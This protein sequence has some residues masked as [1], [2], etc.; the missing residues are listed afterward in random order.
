MSIDQER[1]KD[2]S[3]RAK[4]DDINEIALKLAGMNQGPITEIWGHVQALW[5]M[6]LDNDAAWTS[7][8][9]AIGAL[10]YLVS[11]IDAIPD[12]IPIIGL[13]DDVGVILAAVVSLGV[14]LSK[15]KK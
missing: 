10:L 14:K 8:A 15:Y 11:T 2:Y 9:I 6:I 13:T 5:A 1:L 12:I 7:K 4:P 3:S